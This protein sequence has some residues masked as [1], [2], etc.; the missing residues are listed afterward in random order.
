M[1]KK[2]LQVSFSFLMVFLLIGFTACTQGNQASPAATATGKAGS[3]DI[4]INYN[5]PSVKGRTIWGEL[6]PYGKVWRAGANQ[7]TTFQT[8]K[9]ITV[10]GK[11]L[12]AGKYSLFAV[13][14]QD[15]WQI[16]FNSQTGQWGTQ[17]DAAKD[18]VKVSVRPRA[19]SSMSE[20][21]AYDVNN[22]GFLLKWGKL[23]VPV[24]IK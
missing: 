12:P 10:E 17:H 19:S 14:G 21:L 23:E 1:N 8:S 7:A 18:V 6:V 24:S 11:K 16:I 13:P 9:D 3:A 5:S 2:H 4:T 20:R 15:E 22:N